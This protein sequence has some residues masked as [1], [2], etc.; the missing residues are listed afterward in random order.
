MMTLMYWIEVYF[1]NGKTLRKE[2]DSLN[3]VY[4]VLVR[5]DE[6]RGRHRVQGIRTGRDEIQTGDKN[7]LEK[8]AI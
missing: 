7:K 1:E 5:Y 8:I 3:E 2:S 6:N 4:K